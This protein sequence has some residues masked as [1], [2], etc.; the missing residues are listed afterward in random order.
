MATGRKVKTHLEEPENHERW[1]VSYADFITLL[2]AFFTVLYAISN[3]DLEKSKEFE[4]SVKRSFAIMG[5]GGNRADSS[6]GE[7]P[8]EIMK[9][10]VN[11]Q[12][13]PFPPKGAGA[14]ELA[15]FLNRQLGAVEKTAAG[16]DFSVHHDSVGVRIRLAASALF[17]SGSSQLRPQS[18]STLDSIGTLLRQAPQKIIVEGHT[19]NQKVQSSLFPTN[20]ELAASRATRVL[21]YLVENQGLASSRVVAIS[22]ADQRPLATNA[23]EAGRSKNRRV[24]ILLVLEQNT[25]SL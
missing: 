14:G 3:K 11:L 22:Y 1:L 5:F 2:F 17:N 10:K 20:W 19:D 12:F 9:N 16:K 18:L 8:Q 25:D 4:E 7:T 15:D 13:D 23:T 24:E 6:A 21:R